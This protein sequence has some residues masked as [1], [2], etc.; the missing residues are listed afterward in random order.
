VKGPYKVKKWAMCLRPAEDMRVSETRVLRREFEDTREK[1]KGGIQSFIC[2]VL[3][4]YYY[5]N[6][7]RNVGWTEHVARMGDEIYN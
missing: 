2:C 7:S 4:R 1:L 5:G 3:H 6:K